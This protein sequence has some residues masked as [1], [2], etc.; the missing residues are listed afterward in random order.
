MELI[1]MHLF[2]F[3]TLAR[4]RVVNKAYNVQASKELR[5]MNR[6]SEILKYL[7]R[8]TVPRIDKYNIVIQR[9]SLADVWSIFN[10][11]YTAHCMASLGYIP[12]YAYIASPEEDDNVQLNFHMT[13]AHPFGLLLNSHNVLKI[14]TMPYIFGSVVFGNS[15]IDTMARMWE[16]LDLMAGGLNHCCVNDPKF[17]SWNSWNLR[18][19]KIDTYSQKAY[20]SETFTLRSDLT[21]A[22]ISTYFTQKATRDSIRGTVFALLMKE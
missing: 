4:L 20:L 7:H 12:R 8:D 13:T 15:I 5:K 17:V 6:A 3:V 2:D 18:M 22:H 11:Q 10:C 19:M 21:F 16:M 1:P 9:L 14:G